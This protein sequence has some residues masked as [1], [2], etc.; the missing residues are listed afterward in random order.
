MAGP[1]NSHKAQCQLYLNERSGQ[2]AECFP[3]CPC[4]Y[5]M[6]ASSPPA[7]SPP[8]GTRV[9]TDEPAWRHPHHAE[10]PFTWESFL[11]CAFR[12]SGKTSKWR[13][14]SLSSYLLRIF[15]FNW[16]IVDVHAEYI[17]RNAGLEEAQAGI[18]IARKSINNLR[19]ADDTTLM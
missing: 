9:T 19:Y 12:G 8:D 11:L 17:M 4:S 3:T 16:S 5:A 14:V 6:S 7:T 13:E 18:K 2:K 1:L 10:S 15:F